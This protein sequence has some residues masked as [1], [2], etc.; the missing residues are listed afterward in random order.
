MTSMKMKDIC[1]KI[2][3]GATPRGGKVPPD[4]IAERTK[5]S[6]YCREASG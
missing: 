6:I 3:S 1:L 5:E 2:G 4:E